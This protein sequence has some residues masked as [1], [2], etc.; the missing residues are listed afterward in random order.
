MDTPLKYPQK[1]LD[2]FDLVKD[3]PAELT[4][5]LEISAYGV[6][7]AI[8]VQ[9]LKPFLDDGLMEGTYYTDGWVFEL[10]DAGKRL[11][12]NQR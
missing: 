3:Y 2:A 9:R 8:S 7:K 4:T 11:V 6:G 12:E 1:P 10:T 5:L